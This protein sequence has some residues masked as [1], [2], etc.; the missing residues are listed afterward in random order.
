MVTVGE[1]REIIKDMP[2]DAVLLHAELI[3]REVGEV[4][5]GLA[6]HDALAGHWYPLS[7]PSPEFAAEYLRRCGAGRPVLLVKGKEREKEKEVPSG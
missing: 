6:H 7:F 1:L 2:D 5:P 3:V 4:K